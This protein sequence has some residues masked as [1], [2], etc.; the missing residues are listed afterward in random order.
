MGQAI[1][2]LTLLHGNCWVGPDTTRSAWRLNPPV[3]FRVLWYVGFWA[4]RQA[5]DEALLF[6]KSKQMFHSLKVRWRPLPSEICF[7]MCQSGKCRLQTHT[8]ETLLCD[9]LDK[10]ASLEAQPGKEPTCQCRRQK[11]LGFY[12]WV[13]KIPWRRQ[14]Q[15][16]E[17][18]VSSGK[19]N[20][21]NDKLKTVNIRDTKLRFTHTCV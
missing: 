17:P 13:R 9:K 1:I 21:H 12:P 18:I 19:W 11:R 4:G 5:W 20:K 6:T 7:K 16:Q 14:Q 3:A 15:T 8:P 2:R 10:W